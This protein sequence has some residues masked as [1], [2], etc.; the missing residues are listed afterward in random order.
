MR[1]TSMKTANYSSLLDQILD[2]LRPSDLHTK[3]SRLAIKTRV[4]RL[5][6]ETDLTATELG[7]RIR[8]EI[9]ALRSWLSGT[10]DLTV[11]TLQ[12]LCLSLHISLGDLVLE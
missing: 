7:S 6:A 11:E 8:R 4:E 3:E 2:K 10:K 5:L 1:K 9:V 12:E